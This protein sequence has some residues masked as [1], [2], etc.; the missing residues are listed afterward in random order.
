MEGFGTSAGNR[1]RR[2]VR[3]MVVLCVVVVVAGVVGMKVFEKVRSRLVGGGTP[4]TGTR[5]SVTETLLEQL[6]EHYGAAGLPWAQAGGDK[7]GGKM[8]VR[9]DETGETVTYEFDA[10]GAKLSPTEIPKDF[11][12]DFPGYEGAAVIGA[13]EED[14]AGDVF[15]VTLAT[16]DAPK[17]A[18]AFYEDALP[19]ADYR[20]VESQAG[21]LRIEKP[22]HVT[23]TVRV[24]RTGARTIV[25]IRLDVE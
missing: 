18:L 6:R 20:V 7:A 5:D 11:P 8:T 23:G 3:R 12:A 17:K 2:T 13:L 19:E 1:G 9:D 25:E 16:G 24:S 14:A 22:P 21:E 4:G 10:D 15:V